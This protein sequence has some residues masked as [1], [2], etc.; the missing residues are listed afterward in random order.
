[1]RSTLTA[2]LLLLLCP[3]AVALTLHGTISSR[4][5]LVNWYLHEIN[6]PFEMAPPRPSPHPFGQVPMLTDD[7]GEVQVFESG[8]ILLYLA[9]RYD[10]RCDTPAKRAKGG[11]DAS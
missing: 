8:A 6:Q 5:P 10:S 4:S 3:A 2:P 11:E 1:M 9:D 7:D